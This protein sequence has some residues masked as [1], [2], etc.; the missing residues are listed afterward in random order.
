MFYENK[1]S[2]KSQFEVEAAAIEAALD[3][4][5]TDDTGPK[6]ELIKLV[7]PPRTAEFEA[8]KE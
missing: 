3:T 1:C 8:M 5:Q 6:E 4:A 2:I 7:V